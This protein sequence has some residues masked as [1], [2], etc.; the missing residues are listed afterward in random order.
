MEQIH[1]I[2]EAVAIYNK[3]ISQLLSNP[4]E[5]ENFLKF[6]SRFYKYRFHE[7]LLLYAQDKDVTACATF[8][9][10]KKIGRYVKPYSKSLKTIYS[11][12]GRLYLKSVFD[13]KDTNSKNDIEFNLWKISEQDA[14][15]ILK[16]KLDMY[17]NENQNSLADIIQSYLSNIMDKDFFD[18]IELPFEQVYNDDFYSVFIESVTA[19]VLNRCN[20]EYKP[21]LSKYNNIVDTQVFKRIGFIVN[22]CSYDLIKILEVEVKEKLKNK[23]WEDLFNERNDFSKNEQNVGG[24]KTNEVSRIDNGW[25]NKRDTGELRT[26]DSK[27]RR[28]NRKTIKRATSKA[29]YIRIYSNSSVR[30]YDSNIKMEQINN[31]IQEKVKTM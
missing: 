25:N 20:V 4:E 28:N 8:E 29:K 23:E 5:W 15:N 18:K 7:N 9:E 19:I 22:K 10:W 24:N 16:D 12:N 1:N 14:I 17:F 31:M 21:D 3:G 26:R 13:L 6:T 30:K 27:S 2:K 11:Q